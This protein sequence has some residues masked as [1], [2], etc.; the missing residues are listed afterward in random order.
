MLATLRRA[1]ILSLVAGVAAALFDV[2]A[3]AV[4]AT[5]PLSGLAWV[6]AVQ[7]AMR[8]AAIDMALIE[9][10]AGPNDMLVPMPN[11]WMSRI[12]G[13]SPGRCSTKAKSGAR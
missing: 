8:G 10:P 6:R 4:A 11:R 13:V 7:P 9:L 3:S 1:V 12:H 2:C 5:Q